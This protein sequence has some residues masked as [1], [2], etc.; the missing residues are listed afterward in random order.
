MRTTAPI[1]TDHGRNRPI[2]RHWEPV[3]KHAERKGHNDHVDLSEVQN[4]FRVPIAPANVKKSARDTSTLSPAI[5]SVACGC[6]QV[7]SPWVIT[8]SAIRSPIVPST[9]REAA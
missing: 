1:Q 8:K 4:E 3:N 6:S 5:R 9:Q 2:P 7:R